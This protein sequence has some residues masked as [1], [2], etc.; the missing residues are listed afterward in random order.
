ML[1]LNDFVPANLRVKFPDANEEAISLLSKM[2]V[3]DPE[4]RITVDEAL[5]HPYLASLHDPNLEPVAET[6]VDWRCIEAVSM[7]IVSFP[8]PSREG[9]SQQ[10]VLSRGIMP[11][12]WRE[13]HLCVDQPPTPLIESLVPT[14]LHMTH[15]CHPR[16][17]DVVVFDEARL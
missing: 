4:K 7:P 1:G 9:T 11:L 17:A 3:L 14:I 8:Y 16:C 15:A 13:N 12:A 5:Q 2:L 10:I 6:R